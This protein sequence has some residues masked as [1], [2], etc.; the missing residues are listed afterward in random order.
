M[1]DQSFRQ[2]L[3]FYEN[4]RDPEYGPPKRYPEYRKHPPSGEHLELC[5][6]AAVGRLSCAQGRVTCFQASCLVA[7]ERQEQMSS[8]S[9]PGGLKP[10]K[11]RLFAN[12]PE[13]PNS[14]NPLSPEALRPFNP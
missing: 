11:A 2:H 4:K 1:L 9:K 7:R 13:S 8:P 14:E 12:G 5:L 10:A 3:G 6:L